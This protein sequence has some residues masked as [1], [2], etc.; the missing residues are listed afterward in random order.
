METVNKLPPCYVKPKELTKQQVINITIMFYFVKKNKY[1]TVI[2]FTVP[3]GPS[4]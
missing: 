4:S 1:Y 3:V 2:L